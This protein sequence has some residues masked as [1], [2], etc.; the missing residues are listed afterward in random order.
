MQ[1]ARQ[2]AE[3]S[4]D[5]EAFRHIALNSLRAINMKFR[6]VDDYSRLILAVDR[7]NSW[8]KQVFPFYKATRED[9]KKSSQV[10]WS[11]MYACIASVRQE[12]EDYFPYQVL[13]FDGAEADDIIGS[14]ARYNTKHNHHTLI[15]SGDKDFIQLQIDNRLVRQYDNVND[16]FHDHPDPKR[17]LFEHVMKGDRGDGIPNVLSPS[18]AFVAK[19]RQKPMRQSMMDKWWDEGID[20]DVVDSA[21][22]KRNITL[23][24][25]TKTPSTIYNQVID[26]IERF[27]PKKCDLYSYFVKFNLPSLAKSI[28]DFK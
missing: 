17:Y 16:R 11:Q 8:R 27:E 5:V 18:N 2:F 25:L 1:A 20:F 24:D 28:G 9:A 13:Y 12:I 3:S 19:I 4:V 6:T 7:P 21:N 10:D 14:I 15:V 26:K 23:V 22:L